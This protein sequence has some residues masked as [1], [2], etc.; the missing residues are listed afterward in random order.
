MGN[1]TKTNLITMITSAT[2][3]SAT[4]ITLIFHIDDMV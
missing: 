3:A 1:K 4:I 2:E